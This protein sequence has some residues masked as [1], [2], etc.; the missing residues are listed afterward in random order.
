MTTAQVSNWS[1]SSLHSLPFLL[2]LSTIQKLCP[3]I[4]ESAFLNTYNF[5]I[6]LVCTS[7]S[8]YS[9]QVTI[10]FQDVVSGHLHHFTVLFHPYQACHTFHVY[11]HY[12]HHPFL[13]PPQTPLR[14]HSN[15]LN[16][17]PDSYS[18]CMSQLHV[19]GRSRMLQFIFFVPPYLSSFL[20]SSLL[21]V[22][23]DEA[24]SC[25]NRLSVTTDFLRYI[26]S[27]LSKNLIN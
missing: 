23:S 2:L 19:C 8:S 24:T 13:F 7:S 10:P 26:L 4:L 17:R 15:Y 3:L 1:C 20:S 12:L 16:P 14:S 18:I 6:T 22:I 11:F 25:G 21:R 5:H 27:L 9:L